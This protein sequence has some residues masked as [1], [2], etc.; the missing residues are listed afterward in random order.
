[1]STEFYNLYYKE[2]SGARL[3]IGS[4]DKETIAETRIMITHEHVEDCVKTQLDRII[5]EYTDPRNVGY[6]GAMWK[7]HQSDNKATPEHLSSINTI[8]FAKP[9]ASVLFT[10]PE[11]PYF[12]RIELWFRP[13]NA[14][15]Y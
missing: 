8:N 7:V 2:Q 15:E 10:Y 4:I 6:N 14:N 1:M 5:T 13:I 9:I 11:A 12:K 3:L